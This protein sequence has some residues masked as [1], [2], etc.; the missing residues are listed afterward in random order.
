MPKE[1]KKFYAYRGDYYLP[2]IE[3]DF[4]DKKF[5]SISDHNFK[6]IIFPESPV[7]GYDLQSIAFYLLNNEIDNVLYARGNSPNAKMYSVQEFLNLQ[8]KEFSFK[9]NIY[10]ILRN[11]K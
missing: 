4:Y 2:W 8:S 9:Y 6:N 5:I 11:R 7:Q 1:Q 3:E 10:N